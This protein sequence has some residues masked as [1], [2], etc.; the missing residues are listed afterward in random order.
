M[1]FIRIIFSDADGTLLK[2]GEILYPR[3]LDLAICDCAAL[4]IP[5]VI[6]SGRTLPALERIFAKNADRL[7]FFALDGAYISA[8]GI[9][10]ADFP[11]GEDAV[12]EIGRLYETPDIIGAEFCTAHN[13]CLLSKNDDLHSSEARRIPDEYL[14]INDISEITDRVYKIILFTRRGYKAEISGLHAVYRGE[15]I[16]ELVREGVDKAF[17]AKFLLDELKIAPSDAAAF[18]DSENDLT[19]LKL[20][21]TP[22]TIYG[23]KHGV[24]AISTR[25]T[26]NVAE[27]VRFLLRDKG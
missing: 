2:N 26:A 23:A 3:D 16:T 14:R 19:L 8:G 13:S 21:G 27:Y 7:I 22:V 5:F 15:T 11:I 10:I 20:V 17:A 6:A 1:S 9:P 25:H 12:S 4:K 18:G 24:F